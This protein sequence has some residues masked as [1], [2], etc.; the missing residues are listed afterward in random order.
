[1]SAEELIIK[2]R[3]VLLKHGIYGIRG[4]SKILSNLD[5]LKSKPFIS[6][7]I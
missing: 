3:T 7:F 1:M 4:L 6:N 2:L 5:E